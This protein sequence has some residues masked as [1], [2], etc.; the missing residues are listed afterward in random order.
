MCFLKKITKELSWRMCCDNCCP[1]LHKCG[2]WHVKWWK[3]NK[4]Q[5]KP[6]KRY[7][8]QPS[9]AASF[10]QVS[11]W[12]KARE[13]TT[14]MCGRCPGT[15]GC[16][17]P[18]LPWMPVWPGFGLQSSRKRRRAPQVVSISTEAPASFKARS[19]KCTP[20]PF[21]AVTDSDCIIVHYFHRYVFRL[22][23]PEALP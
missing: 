19:L 20:I 1:A 8:P 6:A 2:R 17:K 23:K 22:T 9:Q 3:I 11:V 4:W 21:L 16:D 10:C 15:R 18:M 5:T 12:G 14:A 13:T 7:K